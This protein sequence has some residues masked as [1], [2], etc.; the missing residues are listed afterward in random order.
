MNM[1]TRIW[2]ATASH[3]KASAY[4]RH[5]AEKVVAHLEVIA[6]Y[7]G[8]SLLRREIDGGVEFLAVTLWKSVDSIRA[9]AGPDP[10]VAVV[11]PEAQALLTTFDR[12]VHNYEVV[13]TDDRSGGGGHRP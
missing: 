6:G 7:E 1:I 9:F 11:D 5:F 10:A 8:A 2:R 13:F 12:S 4:H 3:A